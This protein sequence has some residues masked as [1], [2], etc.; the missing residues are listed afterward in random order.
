MTYWGFLRV[1]LSHSSLFEAVLC[2]AQCCVRLEELVMLTAWSQA[3][4]S[5]VAGCVTKVEVTDACTGS[6]CLTATLT[7]SCGDT[8][9]A[10]CLPQ[11]SQG[12]GFTIVSVYDIC[13]KVRCEVSV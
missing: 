3:W 2:Q 12:Q 6:I 10:L 1:M 11:Y 9:F 7:A 4:H 5:N 13:D 8:Q